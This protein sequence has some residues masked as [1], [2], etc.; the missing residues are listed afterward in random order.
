MAKVSHGEYGAFTTPNGIRFQRNNRLTSEKAVPLEVAALLKK[1]LGA[2]DPI[3][4]EVP[5]TPKF[6]MP[7][8]EEKARLRAESLQVPPELQRTPEQMVEATPP[9]LGIV[10]TTTAETPL[11]KDDFVDN[12]NPEEPT[13]TLEPSVDADFLEQVSIH[14]ASVF[15]IA[16][17]L[18]NRFGIYSVYLDR[19]PEAD[20]VNPLTG[21]LFS[22]YH[23]GI[24][25]Q[26]SIRAKNQGTI[27]RNPEMG[28]KMV[29]EGRAASADLPLDTQPATMGEA[30][31]TNAFAYRTSPR[32][33]QAE[34]K[35]EIIHVRQPDGTI[36]AERRDIPE[37]EVGQANGANQ[38]YDKDEDQPLVEPAFGKQVIRP[39]W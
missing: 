13:T 22:K 31:R 5:K 3:V 36:V 38:R 7:S 16:E 21:E 39:N 6:P 20:E 4:N 14:S 35:S 28:R 37:G 19:L 18:Y 33:Q 9:E 25:Y 32:A 30:R 11:T 12:Y 29:D 2:A 17:A 1:Q 15:D 10:D 27:H 26:A 8:E 24:A 34:P 23:H